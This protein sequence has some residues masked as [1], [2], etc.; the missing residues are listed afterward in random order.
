MIPVQV[1]AKR[2]LV[3]VPH[4]AAVAGLYPE[5]K[6]LD[7]AG[8][9][10]V[11]LPHGPVETFM[12]RRLG[13]D[14]PAPILSHYVWPGFVTPFDVQ[15]KT[16]ALMTLNQRA[17]VLNDKGTGKTK[18]ALWAWDYLRSNNMAGKLIVV[19][20]LSTL[21]ITWADE[22]FS[23]LSHR[24]CVVLHGDKTRRV[25]RLADPEAEMNRLGKYLIVEDEVV[26]VRI[27]RKGFQNLPG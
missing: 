20:P 18:S 12:L 21:N 16:C 22:V 10:H 9:A 23:T 5:A 1:S 3:G 15:K 24:K 2:K 8:A 27:Q 11:L 13:F 7:F 26:R 19:A 4:S 17:Y 25:K 14:V 6:V